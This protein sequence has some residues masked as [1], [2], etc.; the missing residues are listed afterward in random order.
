MKILET[1]QILKVCP[2]WRLWLRTKAYWTD[3]PELCLHSIDTEISDHLLP[4]LRCILLLMREFL[5]RIHLSKQS[6]KVYCRMQT[7]YQTVNLGVSIQLRKSFSKN[8]HMNGKTF[9]ETWFQPM[10]T[11][12]DAAIFLIL[13]NNVSNSRFPSPKRNSEESLRASQSKI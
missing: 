13:T 4:S 9:T 6:H 11:I 12:L 1:I 10:R 8:S 3:S 5:M 2:N 7:T